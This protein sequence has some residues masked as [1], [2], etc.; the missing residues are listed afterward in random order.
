[1]PQCV[2]GNWKHCDTLVGKGSLY[3]SM[4]DTSYRARVRATIIN[5]AERSRLR[6]YHKM[7]EKHQRVE[8]ARKARILD[9]M[10]RNIEELKA[11]Q[12]ILSENFRAE[13]FKSLKFGFKPRRDIQTPSSF[14]RYQLET[15]LLNSRFC[16][17]TLHSQVKQTLDDM[18]PDRQREA[19]REQL[20]REAKQRSNFL[21]DRKLTDQ[22]K[23]RSL[24]V[25]S[26][27]VSFL[28]PKREQPAKRSDT[29]LTEGGE[30]DHFQ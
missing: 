12:K 13:C 7:L 26:S 19:V 24:M 25:D 1:M 15:K 27:V 28:L 11:Y 8:N 23:R 29:F 9:G 5:E 2:N 10:R 14:Q 3:T 18:K 30:E 21:I 20:L 16:K 6:L 4:L 17:E 22:A